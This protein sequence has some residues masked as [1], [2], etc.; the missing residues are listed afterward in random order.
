MLKQITGGSTTLS[1]KNL[2]TEAALNYSTVKITFLWA[3]HIKNK[4]ICENF[5][6][7]TYNKNLN[8]ILK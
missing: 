7:A 2:Y 1:L 3:K 8:L 5:K 6:L 4:I